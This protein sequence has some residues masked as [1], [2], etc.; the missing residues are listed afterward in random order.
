MRSAMP[1]ARAR[2]FAAC[3]NGSTMKDTSMLRRADSS[4]RALARAFVLRDRPQPRV[5]SSTGA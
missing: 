1:R 5:P 2:A 3:Y 4:M